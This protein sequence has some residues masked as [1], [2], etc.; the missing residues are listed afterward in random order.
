MVSEA[1]G[2]GG[3]A[4]T[5]LRGTLRHEDA[6]TQ[7]RQNDLRAAEAR[8]D[9]AKR[10]MAD[11]AEELQ[12]ARAELGAARRRAGIRPPEHWEDPGTDGGR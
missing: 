7:G 5:V 6:L 3:P 12:A 10:R 2:A 4:V 11:A 8:V 1:H 9:A